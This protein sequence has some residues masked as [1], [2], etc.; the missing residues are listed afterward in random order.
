MSEVSRK[1]IQNLNGNDA[2]DWVHKSAR[3]FVFPLETA[4]ILSS[5]G[6]TFFS[7]ERQ[8]PSSASA[9]RL[10]PVFIPSSLLYPSGAVLDEG[11]F[12]YNVCTADGWGLA[13]KQ[14]IHCE[15]VTVTGGGRGSEV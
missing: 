3:L 13:Q 12:A 15:I 7:R 8:T 10:Q 5:G 4:P 2:L 9:D 11:T 14:A 6:G 1:E